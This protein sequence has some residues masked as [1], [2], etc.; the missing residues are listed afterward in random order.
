[1]PDDLGLRRGSLVRRI[2]A[3]VVEGCG[4]GWLADGLAT[5]RT[6]RMAGDLRMP[7]RARTGAAAALTATSVDGDKVKFDVKVDDK[8]KS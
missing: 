2:A 6:R 8:A 3:P 7:Y 5:V 4:L 1:M